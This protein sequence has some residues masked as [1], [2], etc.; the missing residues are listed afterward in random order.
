MECSTAEYFLVSYM[1][2]FVTDTLKRQ[3]F[4]LWNWYIVFK[5]LSLLK[6]EN[7]RRKKKKKLDMCNKHGQALTRM[8]LLMAAGD[9]Q[10]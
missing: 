3:Q 4:M 2:P 9:H 10:S 8:T 7:F 5:E 6:N 1:L